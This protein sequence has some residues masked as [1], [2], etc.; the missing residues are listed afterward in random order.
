METLWWLYWAFMWLSLY[1]SSNGAFY[2]V[3]LIFILQTV[4]W[5]HFKHQGLQ[6][7]NIYMSIQL[8]YSSTPKLTLLSF[9]LQI[10]DSIFILIQNGSH[11]RCCIVATKINPIVFIVDLKKAEMQ[12]SRYWSTENGMSEMFMGNTWV[13]NSYLPTQRYKS[14]ICTSLHYLGYNHFFL[15]Y[16]SYEQ[17][18]YS[19]HIKKQRCSSF[20]QARG[21]SYIPHEQDQ[22][23]PKQENISH[24]QKKVLTWLVCSRHIL[25]VFLLCTLFY[26]LILTPKVV[27]MP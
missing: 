4:L 17:G 23:A 15:T 19:L 18:Y 2:C 10:I 21:R 7:Y 9:Q 12:D 5:V 26:F 16:S 25:I 24:P 22:C 6:I 13:P 27:Y 1:W 8:R 14:N 20:Y 11:Q 3:T